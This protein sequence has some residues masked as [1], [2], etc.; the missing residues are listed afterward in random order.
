M[1]MPPLP[2][3]LEQRQSLFIRTYG[4]GIDLQSPD[5][6]WNNHFGQK[7]TWLQETRSLVDGQPLTAFTRAA[8]AGDVTAAIANWGTEG[9]QFSNVDYTLTLSRLPDGPTSGWP[10]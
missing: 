10:S 4:W 6:Q 8:I 7:Y 9:L 3:R 1:P 2:T 5:P